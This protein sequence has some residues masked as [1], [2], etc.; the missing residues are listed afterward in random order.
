MKGFCLRAKSESE[1]CLKNYIMKVQTQF[2]KKVKFV[3]HDGAREF[4]TGPQMSKWSS[5]NVS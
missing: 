1:E 5:S 4:A 3:R 2:G